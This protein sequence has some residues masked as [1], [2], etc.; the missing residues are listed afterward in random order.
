MRRLPAILSIAC[1]GLAPAGSRLAQTPG[2]KDRARDDRIA[3]LEHKLD[4]VVKELD[5]LRAGSTVPETEAELT[6][7][8]G[9]GPAASKVYSLT[10]GVS[11]GGYAEGSY[12]RVTEDASGDSSDTW[13]LTRAVLYVGYKFNE[14]LVW[15]SEIEFEHATT[16][17]EGS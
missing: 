10:R 9:Y 15:N 11:L 5:T 17:Q 13:D 4:V 8:N 14:K 3:E 2:D 6:S 16:E 7:A 12:T 1:L